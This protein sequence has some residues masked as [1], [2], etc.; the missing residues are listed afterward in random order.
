[1]LTQLI[2]TSVAAGARRPGVARQIALAKPPQFHIKNDKGFGGI[3]PGLRI[4]TW[5]TRPPQPEIAPVIEH[6]IGMGHS[7]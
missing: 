2:V 3:F 4:E 6:G 5:G 7:L 1:M